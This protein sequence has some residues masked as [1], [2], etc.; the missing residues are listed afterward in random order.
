[1]TMDAGEIAD[2]TDIDLQ[3]FRKSPP[4][5]QPLFA[6]DPVKRI[7]WRCDSLDFTFF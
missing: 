4:Q 7:H 2:F 5:S 3:H 6:Q 1:M